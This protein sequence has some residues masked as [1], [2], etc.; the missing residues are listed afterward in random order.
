MAQ[1]AILRKQLE[2]AQAQ[3]AVERQQK[4]YMERKNNELREQSLAIAN[5]ADQLYSTV[6]QLRTSITP[7]QPP[8]D[9]QKREEL[10]RRLELARQAKAKNAKK[11]GKK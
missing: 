1:A 4:A 7:P 3:L 5:Q 9:L 10:L 11:K 6:N 2:E 8:V